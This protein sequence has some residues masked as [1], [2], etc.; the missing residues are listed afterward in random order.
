MHLEGA[1]GP[2]L[3][4]SLASRNNVA[5]P[6]E[7]SFASPSALLDRY[8]RFTSLDDF[9]Y[10][11]FIGMSVLIHE[12]DFEALAWEYFV[13]AKEDG[14]MHAEVFFD[15]Q[16]HTGRGV[17]YKTVLGGFVKACRRAEEELGMSTML[18]LCFLRHLPPTEADSM[19]EDA[20]GDLVDGT[21]AGIGM[22]S[23]EKD[24]PPE[25]FRKVYASAK[26]LGIR[27]TAHA[28]EEAG[29]D[30]IKAALEHLDL[31]RIDHGRR[32]AED[33]ELI[34]EV[35]ERKLLVTICPISNLKLQ[36]V[37][38]IGEMPVRTFLDKGVKFS[39]NS[40]DPAYFGGYILDNYCAVQEAFDLTVEE[41]ES[42]AR[43]A[44]EGSWCAES[45]K[46]TILQ[47][48]ATV[49]KNFKAEQ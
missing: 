11:Y 4:F 9:L 48:L 10:Y 34:A 45:R 16:A 7:P 36:G 19:F 21:L 17:A 15:P 42:I 25:L 24:R 2:S 33:E 28:G 47:A 12:T 14:V 27:R 49:V 1:L 30:M 23:T 3:L 35:A 39:I 31:Q 32:M 6:S 26:E 41:W 18:I 8:A 37:Q 20:K 5:L 46:M 40:D 38:S 13:K 22:D 43:A 44:V 29:A